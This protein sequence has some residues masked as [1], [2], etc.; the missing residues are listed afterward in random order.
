MNEPCSSSATSPA[1]DGP[2]DGLSSLDEPGSRRRAAAPRQPPRVRP[3]GARPRRRRRPRR[4][5]RAAVVRGRPGAP[6]LP[7]RGARALRRVG[8]R[9]ESGRR[10]GLACGRTPQ[11]RAAAGLPAGLGAPAT[12]LGAGRPARCSCASRCGPRRRRVGRH[13]SRPASRRSVGRGR[14]GPLPRGGPGRS[15]PPSAAASTVGSAPLPAASQL[16]PSWRTRTFGCVSASRAPAH[17]GSIRW[18]SEERHRFLRH[19]AAPRSA[20]CSRALE[21]RARPPCSY[22]SSNLNS[23]SRRTVALCISRSARRWC[24]V[25]PASSS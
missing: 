4:V 19:C 23:F 17:Q 3:R 7:G 10:P 6:A 15:R 8:H 2:P 13:A 12:R 21:A 22:A 20:G 25:N 24:A 18:R 1:A 14:R 5:P 11:P 16:P 9:S